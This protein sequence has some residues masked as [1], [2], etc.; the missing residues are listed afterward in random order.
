M[1]CSAPPGKAVPIDSKPHA[2]SPS[3]RCSGYIPCGSASTCNPIPGARTANRKTH[4]FRVWRRWRVA[5]EGRNRLAISYCPAP[6]SVR[7]SSASVVRRHHR[8]GPLANAARTA[9]S[10][11]C[12]CFPS[13]LAGFTQR[14]TGSWTSG[15]SMCVVPPSALPRRT[16]INS[17]GFRRGIR[18]APVDATSH[19]ECCCGTGFV[20]RRAASEH[21]MIVVND[22]RPT[23]AAVQRGTVGRVCPCWGSPNSDLAGSLASCAPPTRKGTQS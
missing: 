20:D 23:P 3:G 19:R 11:C 16:M 21:P 4:S 5:R 8:S 14:S 15:S 6:G 17:S 13:L 1:R 12:S 10:N 2:E 9:S 18:T 7:S 22:L